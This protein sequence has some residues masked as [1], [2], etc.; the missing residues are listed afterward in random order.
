[1]EKYRKQGRIIHIQRE[2]KYTKR[3]KIYKENKNT[4]TK[5]LAFRKGEHIQRENKNRTERIEIQSK[6]REIQNKEKQNT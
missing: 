2:E 4:Y 3:R 5:I 1:M 6:G